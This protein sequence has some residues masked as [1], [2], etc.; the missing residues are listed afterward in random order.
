M[1]TQGLEDRMAKM[2][3]QMA[4]MAKQNA[5]LEHELG[6]LQDAREIENL[7]STYEY[8][9]TCNDHTAIMEM[10]AK[11]VDDIY[12]NIATRGHWAG[13]DAAQRAWGYFIDNPRYE[14]G[15]MPL[16]PTTTPIIEVA[17]DRKTAKG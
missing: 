1:V 13:K 3:K 12:V 8:L 6:R 2:E 7:M 17:A 5:E 16:H 15:F 10:Y 4:E 9:H 14:K 11:N